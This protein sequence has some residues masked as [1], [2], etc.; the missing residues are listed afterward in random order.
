MYYVLELVGRDPT[1]ISFERCDNF[2]ALEE[3]SS[4]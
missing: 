4:Y 1:S 2:Q 3:H